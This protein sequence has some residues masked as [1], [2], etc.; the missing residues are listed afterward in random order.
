MSDSE[1]EIDYNEVLRTLDSRNIYLKIQEPNF[2]ELKAK[3]DDTLGKCQENRNILLKL[4]EEFQIEQLEILKSNIML[5]DL[6]NQS[7]TQMETL[8]N[9]KM[10]ADELKQKLLQK[11]TDFDSSCEMYIEKFDQISPDTNGETLKEKCQQNECIIKSLQKESEMIKKNISLVLQKED[12]KYDL[13][14]MEECTRLMEEN[15]NEY[16]ANLNKYH[17]LI[18]EI[19]EMENLV[20]NFESENPADLLLC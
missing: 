18:N 9:L 12:A 14:G 8:E 10:T 19:N 2:K 1:T 11:Q 20:K 4:R 16:E 6:R 7:I 17:V 13:K 15:S 5:G 3:Y